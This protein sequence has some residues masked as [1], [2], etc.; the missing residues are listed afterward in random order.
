MG[1]QAR[2]A[3]S[4][5]LDVEIV[6]KRPVEMDNNLGR[7]AAAA[8]LRLAG[9]V[10][11][12]R[13]LGSVE[14]EQDGRIYFGDRT[15]YIER[16]TV[17]FLDSPK[18]TPELD[19]HASTRS[20]SYTV[21]LGLTGQLKELTTTFTSDPPLPRDDVIA[22]L[23][24]GKTVAENPGVDLR[25]LEGYALASGA[26]SASLSSRLNRRF[27]VSRVSIQPSAVAA[28]SNPGARI[29]FTQDFTSTFRLM[30]SM[31][32]SDSND[33]IWVT[34]YDLSRRFTTRAVKQSDNSYR[35]EFR[36]D[37][38]FGSSSV[39]TSSAPRPPMPK[40]SGVDFVGG[41]PFS[42]ADLA[43]QFKIRTGQRPS[44]AKLRTSSEKLSRFLM[45]KGYLESR[46][47]VDRDDN[48]QDMSLTVRIELGPRVEMAYE[49][50]K[51]SRKQKARVRGVW[52]AG[53]SNQQRVD[54]AKNSILDYLAEKGYLRAELTSEVLRKDD[55]KLVRFQLRPGTRFRDVKIEV[56]GAGGDRAR[57]ILSLLQQPQLRQSVYRDPRRAS[58]AIRRFYE[59]RGYLAASMAA[60]VYELDAQ[61]QTGKI[62]IPIE[63]GPVF[64]V[65]TLQF[66]GNT[67]LTSDDLRAGLPLETGG[68]F[69]PAR[70]EPASTA[71]KL[72]YGQLGYGD[73]D[74]DY[75]IARHDE[76]ASVDVS[77]QVIENKQTTIGAVNVEGNRRTSAEFAR[78]RMRVASGEV[79]NTAL[80]RESAS[81]PYTNRSIR[82]CGRTTAAGRTI[83][84]RRQTSAG[85]G[86]AGQRCGAETLPSAL[87]RPL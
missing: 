87:R 29:T 81:E 82:F 64:R 2:A 27:G 32:L 77:F 69:E 39:Q 85:R 16:G 49:G 80:L 13:V 3:S 56:E 25:S 74:I 63:E 52:H 31:N 7:L 65:G 5:V 34:E 12:P 28:E 66:T 44:A 17:R 1:T 76:R 11:Q 71:L 61:R 20:G 14:L 15:Y 86:P 33:Q 26:I 70:L 6:T 67:A 4:P 9:T 54:A 48:G 68:V 75:E 46:V 45:E 21:N 43:K 72:K 51:L 23:L 41:G 35:G 78:G 50:A 8:N 47:R 58:A 42:P 59:Q 73:A 83:G 18:P 53:I 19:I 79:A 55:E 22:V 62:V 30:Y 57:D 40:V 24:T 38:R 37:V 36:H 84:G 10:T 60:P